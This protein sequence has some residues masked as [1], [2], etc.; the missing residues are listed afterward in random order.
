[1]AGH[2]FNKDELDRIFRDCLDK[3]LGELDNAGVFKRTEHNP[4]ITG[5]AGDVVEQ[6][7][8]GYPADSVQEPDLIV[9]GTPTELKTTGLRKSSSRGNADFSYEAKEPMSITAVSPD[10]ITTEDFED[11]AFWHKL[12]HMLIVYYLYDSKTTVTADRYAN[13][14]IK[15][16]EF[17]EFTEAD[18]GILKSDWETVRDFIWLAQETLNDPTQ[19]YPEISHLRDQLLYVDTA[20]KWPHPPR[21][22]LKRSVV[23]EIAHEHFGKGFKQ[24]ELDIHG[25]D[26]VERML[27][28]IRLRYQGKTITEIAQEIDLRLGDKPNKSI[29][30]RLFVRLLGSD[31]R[32]L[33]GISIFA[34]AGFILKSITLTNHGLRTEDMKMARIDFG[35][36]C[37]PTVEFEDSEVYSYFADHA[38]I[39]M[40]FQEP[41][42][43][44]P[45]ANNV[46]KDF[47]MMHFSDAFIETSVRKTWETVRTLVCNK[48]LVERPILD[49]EGNVRYNKAT[50][51]GKPVVMT[52]LNFPKSKDSIVFLRG[53]GEDSANKTECVNGIKMYPQAFW[54]KGSYIAEWL[55]A[56]SV[57]QVE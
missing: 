18:K 53:S 17:H 24:P 22:R 6:S 28:S 7:I 55:H 5:I 44:A 37:D 54:L 32:K 21:F 48:T 31:A 39:L 40:I 50:I 20:P 1:M 36:W 45:L 56:E 46:F 16:Y 23:S 14:P 52:E 34:K 10:T 26:D 19:K 43:N 2:R 13:F 12:A 51:D 9:D 47:K 15:G 29:V 57:R 38:I 4:K 42:Q 25:I 49:R 27:R 41:S 35:E 33:N 11:S 30:E 8:L 3:T